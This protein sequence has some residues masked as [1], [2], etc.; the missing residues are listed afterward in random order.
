VGPC[1]RREGTRCAS[2]ILGGPIAFVC[3]SGERL[4]DGGRKL[5]DEGVARGGC[6]EVSGAMRARVL[7][8]V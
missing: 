7:G 3:L 6:E 8:E 5:E 4:V 1:E 2:G